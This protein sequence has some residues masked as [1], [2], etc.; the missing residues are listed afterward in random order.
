MWVAA[1]LGGV[2]MVVVV[3]LMVM[4]N[5]G[6]LPA[7]NMMLARYAPAH[8]HG[9]A[10]GAKFV[11]AF[12]AAPIA[13]QLVSLIQDHSGDL[14]LVFQSFAVCAALALAAILMLPATPRT[15]AATMET[16]S[17]AA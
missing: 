10:F 11:L 15:G 5:V 1:S 17:A 2:S 14:G 3:T 4:A 8:R 9:L 16:H 13:V 7:E 6:A 12:G